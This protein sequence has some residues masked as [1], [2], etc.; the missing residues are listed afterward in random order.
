LKDIGNIKLIYGISTPEENKKPEFSHLHEVVTPYNV[1]KLLHGRDAVIESLLE[2]CQCAYR[3]HALND[4]NIG[5]EELSD[6]LLD[7]LCNAMGNHGY[8]NW[9]HDL[10]AQNKIEQGVQAE[11]V[12]RPKNDF[13][14]EELDIIHKL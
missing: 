8:D 7:A 11:P 14:K 10:K 12:K 5:W 13:T 9:L 4:D 1:G 3:K 6:K 2:A